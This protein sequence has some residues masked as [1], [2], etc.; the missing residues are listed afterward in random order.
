MS[1]SSRNVF[2]AAALALAAI[3]AYVAW[4]AHAKRLQKQA[5]AELVGQG[6]AALA[7]SIEAAP[8][9]AEIAAAERAALAIAESP[10]PGQVAL[11]RAADQYLANARVIVQRRA[12]AQQVLARAAA[13]REALLQHLSAKGRRDGAWIRG[14]A[15]LKRKADQDQAD[16]DRGLNALA[17]LL[18]ATPELEASLARH[19]DRSLLVPEPLLA[20]A[21]RQAR[22]QAMRS[23][24]EL[25]QVRRL[26]AR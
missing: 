25:D 4:T 18:D 23:A 19:L 15:E 10:A 24:A 7:K 22:E 1:S 12:D 20:S 13:S 9:A 26:A 8:G 11:T 17:D 5:V 16:L 3:V 14:A 21:A 2:I 6:S